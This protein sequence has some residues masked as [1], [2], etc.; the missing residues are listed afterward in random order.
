MKTRLALPVILLVALGL[1][2]P[3][4]CSDRD[5]PLSP[6]N[7]DL[8][9][10]D[11]KPKTIDIKFDG[12]GYFEVSFDAESGLLVFSP[13]GGYDLVNISHFGLSRIVWELRVMPV[14]YAF[15]DGWFGITGANGRDGLSGVYSDFVLGVGEYD[16]DW[17]FTGGTGRFVSAAGTGHTDGVVDLATG[18]AEFE[19]RGT[20]TY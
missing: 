18:Y 10:L 17:L 20:V 19:F 16:L 6:R 5:V 14:T 11:K 12:E 15:V 8:S 4:G 7:D 9:G 1:A 3:S 13:Q 2:L